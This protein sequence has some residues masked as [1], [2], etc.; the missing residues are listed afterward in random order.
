MIKRQHDAF[1]VAHT[2]RRF[3]AGRESDWD[4]DDFTSCSISDPDLD[5]IRRRAALVDLPAGREELAALERLADEAERLAQ[6]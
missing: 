3:V 2:I 4:W 5:G 1:Y 6:R